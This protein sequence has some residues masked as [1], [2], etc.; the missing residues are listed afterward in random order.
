PELEAAVDFFRRLLQPF[1]PLTED[2]WRHLATHSVEEIAPGGACRMRCDP[3]IAK[4]FRPVRAFNLN[5]W[6]Y[7]NSIT[8]PTLLL[9]GAS[10][11]LLPSDVASEMTRRGPRA[12]L[13]EFENCGHAP[14]LLDDKQID[15]VCDW[16]A[17]RS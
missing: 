9:R 4:A 10:S 2:D 7:W 17:G 11:D 16:L 1:G 14:A 13:V 6:H 8:A 15:T 3:G 5:L 12:A